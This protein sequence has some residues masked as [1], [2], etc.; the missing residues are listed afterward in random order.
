MAKN[1]SVRDV[2]DAFSSIISD[3]DQALR[4]LRGAQ[5]DLAEQNR[6]ALENFNQ[7]T[8]RFADFIL[9]PSSTLL[10]SEIDAALE[11]N[12]ISGHKKDL[13][14]RSAHAARRFAEESKGLP[15]DHF[16]RK[17]DAA[18]FFVK[19][20][21]RELFELNSS[22]ESQEEE[23]KGILRFNAYA[24][25]PI[26]IETANTDYNKSGFSH[27]ASWLFNAEYRKGYSLINNFNKK[28]AGTS[29][30][31][32]LKEIK[33]KKE[34]QKDQ[35]KGL[36]NAKEVLDSARY[37]LE[38]LRNLKNKIKSPNE[39]DSDVRVY[40]K[41][42]FRDSSLVKKIQDASKDLFP[43]EIL[44][45]AAKIDAYAK[46]DQTLTR[47]ISNL[48][49]TNETLSTHVS[50]LARAK[51]NG[52]G[53][54]MIP[55]DLDTIKKSCENQRVLSRHVT[56]EIAKAGQCVDAF[57]YQE[58]R[59][60]TTYVPETPVLS[61]DTFTHMM[62]WGMLMQNNDFPNIDPYVVNNIFDAIPA[63]VTSGLN[64]D[65]SSLVSP[66]IDMDSLS[67]QFNNS[68]FNVDTNSFNTSGLDSL[69]IDT[70]SISIPDISTPD[71]GGTFDS[72]GGGFDA[73]GGGLGD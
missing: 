38:S 31:S 35:E 41:S 30:V 43:L 40:T 23:I 49:K 54:K 50:K 24:Q 42:L 70:G 10:L 71:L 12:S 58:Q 34:K 67:T 13:E 56:A 7:S 36:R 1:H 65:T 68:V 28:N 3:N 59:H 37:T 66:S 14:T 6:T 20:T 29:L 17:A 55:I 52:N 57:D 18:L 9:S 44:E 5:S 22:L 16:E 39:I 45:A 2:H 15:L 4:E 64:I 27:I 25:K 33:D 47:H 48:K 46:M 63:D 11:T 62:M 73:G 51:Y 69:S 21:G 72:G 60:K 32:H 26:S 8:D 53:S 61:T 19:E